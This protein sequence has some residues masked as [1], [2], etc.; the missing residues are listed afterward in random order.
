MPTA[1]SDFLLAQNICNQQLLYGASHRR[2]NKKSTEKRAGNYKARFTAADYVT[3]T[4]NTKKT[5]E[6]PAYRIDTSSR[7]V[8]E[9]M[10]EEYMRE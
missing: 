1:S 4:T 2:G 10:H 6:G 5:E 8:T 7:G 3:N 9:R